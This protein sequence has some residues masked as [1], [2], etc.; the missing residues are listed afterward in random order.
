MIERE[1]ITFNRN[2]KNILYPDYC[3]KCN[4]PTISEPVNEKKLIKIKLIKF[5]ELSKR[6]GKER[7]I[8]MAKCSKCGT[9]KSIE[10]KLSK[11]ERDVLYRYYLT[12]SQNSLSG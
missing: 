5:R 11:P 4:N 6:G 2:L 8:D 7:T 10:Y 1:E 9:K 3:W 12:H